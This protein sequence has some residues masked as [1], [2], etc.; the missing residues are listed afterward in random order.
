MS[1]TEG[2]SLGLFRS[3]TYVCARTVLQK[4]AKTTTSN[5]LLP[6]LKTK[7]KKAKS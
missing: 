1:V 6:N 5:K 2:A 7:K 4:S 3:A